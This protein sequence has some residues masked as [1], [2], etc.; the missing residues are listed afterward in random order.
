MDVVALP[1]YGNTCF[2]NAV[3]QLLLSTDILEHDIIHHHELHNATGMHPMSVA[4]WILM[5]TILTFTDLLK[6]SVGCICSVNAYCKYRCGRYHTSHWY[7]WTLTLVEDVE[8]GQCFCVNLICSCSVLA[9]CRRPACAP[10][11]Y[12]FYTAAMAPC[13]VNSSLQFL[14]HLLRVYLSGQWKVFYIVQLLQIS[15]P[16]IHNVNNVFLAV[17]S[18]CYFCLWS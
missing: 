1:N 9:C 15:W 13:N 14:C 2:M 6:S 11:W 16:I 8:W 12:F 17:V 5:L 10:L 7:C 18:D 4:C 3:V